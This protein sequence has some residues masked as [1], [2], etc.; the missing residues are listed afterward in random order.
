MRKRFALGVL[1]L[2]VFAGMAVAEEVTG[3]IL[4]EPQKTTGGYLYSIATGENSRIADKRMEIVFDGSG[5]YIRDLQNYLVR[6]AKIVYDNGAW[7]ISGTNFELQPPMRN[8]MG[9][10]IRWNRLIA[11]IMEDGYYI[12][13]EELFPETWASD[14][15]YLY[16]KLEREGRIV[17]GRFVR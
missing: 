17:N 3:T 8:T 13:I 16:D 5:Y 2:A 4:F 11:I 12:G 10:Y 1:V 9:E 15:P 14:F 6:G 7:M